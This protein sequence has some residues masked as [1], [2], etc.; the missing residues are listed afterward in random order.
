VVMDASP[1]HELPIPPHLTAR[2]PRLE[3]MR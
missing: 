2:I 3:G 1:D